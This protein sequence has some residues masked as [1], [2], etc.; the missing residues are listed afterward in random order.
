MIVLLCFTINVTNF[1]ISSFVSWFKILSQYGAG[2]VFLLGFGRAMQISQDDVS[3]AFKFHNF[4][5]IVCS[6]M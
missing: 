3:I 1:I 2:I 6:L 5:Q 4:V